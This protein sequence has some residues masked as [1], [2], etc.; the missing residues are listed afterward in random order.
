[1]SYRH[2]DRRHPRRDSSADPILLLLIPVPMG[3][4]NRNFM[5][6]DLEDTVQVFTR[7]QLR[8]DQLFQDP[9]DDKSADG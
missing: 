1:M 8:K 7:R 3:M 4:M 6:S 5:S 9:S 2:A